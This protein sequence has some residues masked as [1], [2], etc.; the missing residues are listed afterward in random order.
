MTYPHSCACPS[1]RE[2]L[3]AVLPGRRVDAPSDTTLLQ[4]LLDG[5]G[6]PRALLLAGGCGSEGCGDRGGAEVPEEGLV[7]AAGQRRSLRG[8][9]E[10][11]E[12]PQGRACP[13]EAPKGLRIIAVPG[14]SFPKRRRKLGDEREGEMLRCPG[15]LRRR[16]LL[17]ILLLRRSFVLLRRGRG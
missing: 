15:C 4:R 17:L 7:E 12:G 3:E 10:G 1:P 16:A 2:R 13:E 11:Q 5:A 9:A 6:A 8:P 14:K